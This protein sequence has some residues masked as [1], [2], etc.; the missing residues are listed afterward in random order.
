MVVLDLSFF[1]LICCVV[2]TDMVVLDLSIVALDLPF[3]VLDLPGS[4]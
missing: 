1:C 3:V 2:V 4:L